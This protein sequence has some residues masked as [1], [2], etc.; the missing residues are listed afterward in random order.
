MS[1][2]FSS[3]VPAPMSPPQ[4]CCLDTCEH[5]RCQRALPSLLQPHAW[6]T[7][8]SLARA[9]PRSAHLLPWG[10]SVDTAQRKPRWSSCICNPNVQERSLPEGQTFDPQGTHG[11]GHTLAP[12]CPRWALLRHF[13][14]SYG[15]GQTSSRDSGGP[16]SGTPSHR[17]SLLPGLTVL[18]R[19]LQ[20]SLCLRPCS[21]GSPGRGSGPPSASP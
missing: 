21:L 20:R 8:Q 19:Y 2:F 11:S 13:P 7:G 4:G 9:G 16:R 15:V 14:P 18:L 10:L 12:S 3:R 17:L 5:F 1:A 6:A